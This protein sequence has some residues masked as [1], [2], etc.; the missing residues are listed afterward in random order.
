M[1]RNWLLAFVCLAAAGCAGDPGPVRI[2]TTWPESPQGYR[3]AYHEWTRQATARSGLDLIMDVTAT[4]KSAEWRASWV[5]AHAGRLALPADE[6]SKLAAA[7]QAA[8]LAG[9]EVELIVATP[10][11]TWQDFA[12][13]S[14]MWR[15]ALVGDDGR[16]VTPLSIKEDGRP[17]G[18]LEVWYPALRGLRRAYVVKFPSVAADGKPLVGEGA[19]RL[20]LKVAGAPGSLRLVWRGQ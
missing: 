18:E 13:T 6:R 16:E 11:M 4:L 15:V 19:A 5:A 2:G 20:T 8:A 7:E 17:R 1:M 12:S 3:A 14:S 9:W 10:N